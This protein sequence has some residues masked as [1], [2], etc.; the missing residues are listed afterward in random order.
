MPRYL[1]VNADD[2]GRSPGVTR[3]IIKA[4]RE[5]IVTSTSVMVNQPYFE[6]SVKLMREYPSLGTG[7]HLVFTLG[8]PVLPPEEIPSLVDEAGFFFTQEA[9]LA[10]PLRVNPA[11]L[12]SEFLAQVERFRQVTGREPDHLDCHHFTH[13]H[14]H[15]FSVY[16]DVAEE[17]G[18]PIRWPL[19]PWEEAEKLIGTTPMRNLSPAEARKLFES[20]Y[21]LLD[22]RELPHP[23]R[24]IGSF[25]GEEAVTLEHLIGLLESVGEGVTELMC[26]PGFVDE[27]LLS[28]SG[29]TYLREKE[30]ELLCHPGVKER[31]KELG[32]ELVNFSIFNPA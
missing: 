30:I 25:F 5:G 24:F 10:D 20:D 7:V 2:F 11:E 23:D 31:V 27:E 28:S 3:G 18:L 19:P 26:H 9:L 15:F 14:P 6:E 13:L 17:L 22:K 8:K 29:Y 21:R 1:I 4:H 16:L 12:R 32:I